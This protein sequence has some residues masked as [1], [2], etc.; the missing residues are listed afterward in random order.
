MR[1]A[2]DRAG[3]TAYVSN[4][5]VAAPFVT[6]IC[7][8]RNARDAV[9]L[10]F[11]TLRRC[12]PEQK[13][14]LVADNDSR[15]GTLG[16]LRSLQWIRVTSFQERQRDD[17]SAVLEHGATLDWLASR[18]DTPF[19]LTLDSDVEFR[20][21]GW[22]SAL[23]ELAERDGL[24]ALGVFEPAIGAYRPRLAPSV[25]LLRTE[26]FRTL[27]TSFRPFVRIVDSIEAARWQARPPRENLEMWELES[28]QTAAFYPTAAALFEQLQA[29]GAPW[30]DMP[31]S[32]ASSFVHL[33]H[34]SWAAAE[35]GHLRIEHHRLRDY[36]RTRL[37]ALH[38]VGGE[39]AQNHLDLEVRQARVLA[40]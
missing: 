37:V 26:A 3:S 17:A 33:G 14:V 12:T 4:A 31:R 27:N 15:D 39:S 29:T 7:A 18:V 25:L 6:I 32:I 40:E 38:D 23:L 13:E 24:A 10:T 34:M 19:F 8:T 36:I 9:Q 21:C 28:Y 2:T 30:A 16:Y 1:R 11:E 35:G 5:Q 20:A 22:L